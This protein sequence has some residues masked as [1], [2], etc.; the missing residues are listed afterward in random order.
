M[1]TILNYSTV[2]QKREQSGYSPI[3]GRDGNLHPSQTTTSTLALNQI[4]PLDSIAMALPIDPNDQRVQT[5]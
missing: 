1:F 3:A 5:A 2:F 4:C